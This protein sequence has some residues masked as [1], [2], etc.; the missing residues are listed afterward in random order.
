M[1]NIN[2]ILMLSIKTFYPDMRTA[3]FETKEDLGPKHDPF[4]TET[5]NKQTTMLY[6]QN[7]IT[8]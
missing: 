8:M 5:I 2:N 6:L 3:G 1:L 7:Y 4:G